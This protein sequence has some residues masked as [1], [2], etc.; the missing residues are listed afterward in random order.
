MHRSRLLFE[1]DPLPKHN[2]QTSESSDRN[3]SRVPSNYSSIIGF[4]RILKLFD[5]YFN[6]KLQVNCLGGPFTVEGID[7]A[8]WNDVD[9]AIQTFWSGSD[10]TIHTCQCGIDDYCVRPDLEC[11]CDANVA[12]PLSDNGI[13][14]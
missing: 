14:F 13:V 8:W 3:F 11:N 4:N 6:N 10:A 9:G 2:C 1:I 7:Y 12:V 5:S